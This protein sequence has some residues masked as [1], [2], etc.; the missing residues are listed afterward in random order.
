MFGEWNGKLWGELAKM[1]L[2]LG[3]CGEE[4]MHA[5]GEHNVLLSRHFCFVGLV[6][7]NLSDQKM[8]G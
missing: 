6:L 2:S 3:F 8:G 7:Q 5:K 1:R 4:V